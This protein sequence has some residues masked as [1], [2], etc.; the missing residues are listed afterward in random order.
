MILLKVAQMMILKLEMMM[1]IK[2]MMMKVVVVKR[3]RRRIP[4]KKL[5]M[6]G[7]LP[8]TIKLSGLDQKKKLKMKNTETSIH[9]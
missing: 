1:V 4:E 2:V 7:K 9:P 3:K 6:I 5:Y 8:M